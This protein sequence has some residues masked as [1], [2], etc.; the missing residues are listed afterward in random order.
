VDAW[1]ARTP[2][3]QAILLGE[4]H[5]HPDH[6]RIERDTVLALAARGKL[7]ALVIEMAEQGRS[8]AGLTSQ[9]SEDQVREALGW[10]PGQNEG[11]PWR[12]Y[13]PVVMAAVRAGAPVWGANPPR[14]R[15]RELMRA[16]DEVRVVGSLE[17]RLPRQALQRQAQAMRDGHCNVL[18]E[19]Q[20]MPMV[21]AQVARDVAMAE[22]VAAALQGNP[23]KPRGQRGAVLLV[24]GQ[25]H[26]DKGLGVP[27]HWPREFGYLVVEMTDGRPQAATENIASADL[28]WASQPGPQTDHCAGF[29]SP[30]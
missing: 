27:L 7:T 28:F 9:A 8:T 25:G 24:A 22:A 10:T 2:P 14:A 30:R 26:T 12:L 17:A 20:V 1:F 13:G 4:R 3:P 21:R 18:P 16:P 19:H 5:D 15:L 6:Q 11:W 29:R 23:A